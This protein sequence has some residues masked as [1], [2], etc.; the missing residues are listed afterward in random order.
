[1]QVITLT[2][3]LLAAAKQGEFPALPIKSD[4]EASPSQLHSN[5]PKLKQ[6][7]H[8]RLNIK[9]ALGFSLSSGLCAKLIFQGFDLTGYSS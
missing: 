1:M 2:E 5:A 6:V 9:A 8:L 4:D 7:S 3:E